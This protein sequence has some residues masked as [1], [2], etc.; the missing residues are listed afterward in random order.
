VAATGNATEREFDRYLARW[1]MEVN[2]AATAA[3]LDSP[4]GRALPLENRLLAT[5]ALGGKPAALGLAAMAPDLARPLSEEEVRVLAAHFAEPAARTALTAALGRDGSRAPVLRALLALRTS[6]DA[7]P[8][9]PALTAAAK[10]LLLRATAADATLAAQVIGAF[11]LSGATTELAAVLT[12][13]GSK[14]PSA[15]LLATLRGLRENRAGSVATFEP[16][17]RGTADPLVKEEAL[18]AWAALPDAE[19]AARLVQLLPTLT[20]AQRRNLV[21]RLV[22]HPAGATAVCRLAGGDVVE[23]GSECRCGGAVATRFSGRRCGDRSWQAHGGD[24]QRALRLP[25]GAAGLRGDRAH[26]RGPFHR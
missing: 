2:Q 17:V 12:W 23:R 9:V 20:L 24:A 13:D 6:I 3:L 4:E 19:A 25:G 15:A 7:T 11:K 14:A 8:L 22:T 5:L 18:A 10:T 1:A 21:E 26:P 16:L